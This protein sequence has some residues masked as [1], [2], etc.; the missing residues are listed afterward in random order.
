MRDICR[1]GSWKARGGTPAYVRVEWGPVS[2]FERASNVYLMALKAVFPKA[3]LI[4]WIGAGMG[5][6]RLTGSW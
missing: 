5:Q 6:I 4:G 1:L 2:N 3:G